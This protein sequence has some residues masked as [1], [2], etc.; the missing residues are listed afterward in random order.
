ME[1]RTA[2]LEDVAREAGVSQQTVSRVLN[3]PGVVT[4]RTRDKVIRAMQALHYVPNRSAQ[5]L[6]GKSAPSIGLIT[7]SLTLHAPSQ[8]AAAIKSHAGKHHLEVAI[9]M[10][11]MADYASLQARLNEFRAQNIRGAVIN[12]PLEGNIAEKLVNENPDICCLFLDVSPETNVC[13][14]RFDHLDGCGACIRHLWELGHREFGLLAGPESSVS[15]RMRLSSWRETLHRLGVS[16]AVTVFG[17]WSAASG[18]HKAFELLH[19]YTRI[20]A[21]VVANDQMALG[22]LS[23]LAQLNRTG[24]RMVSVTGYDDT[25]DSLYFQPPL[26]TVAQDFNKLGKRAVELLIQQMAAPQMHLRELL[27]TRL[28]IRESTR[29]FGR[30]EEDEKKSVI[31]QLKSLIEKL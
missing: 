5:L 6:A 1:R 18:W 23:A 3:K 2:T 7:A 31:A 28:I 10:P 16:N 8:I 24:S 14:V 25:A 13:C 11:V 20:S 12:L 30:E 27:P 19:Q 15:A 22:V 29:P 17:D 9:A 26:T 21:I 4:E